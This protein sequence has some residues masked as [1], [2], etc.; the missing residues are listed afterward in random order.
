MIDYHVF[1]NIGMPE[2][3]P[4]AKNLGVSIWGQEY[5]Y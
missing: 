2:N 1:V 5:I 4:W 3:L